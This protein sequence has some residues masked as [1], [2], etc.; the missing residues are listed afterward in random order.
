LQRVI[1]YTQN[2]DWRRKAERNQLWKHMLF[3]LQVGPVHPLRYY[4]QRQY[5]R[6]LDPIQSIGQEL[7]QRI[8]A[9]PTLAQRRT[10]EDHILQVLGAQGFAESPAATTEQSTQEAPASAG[11]TG[12]AASTQ[13]WPPEPVF[14]EEGSAN[15]EPSGVNMGP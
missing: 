2:E 6:M 10:A 5:M 3:E 14:D 12:Q 8:D 13:P 7:K 9:I 11:E 1:H 4:L 15:Q